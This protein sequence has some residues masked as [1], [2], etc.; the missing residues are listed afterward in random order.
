MP[1]ALYWH[2]SN[3]AVSVLENFQIYAAKKIQRFYERVPNLV[4]LYAVDEAGAFRASQENDVHPLCY[5][6]E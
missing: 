1:T 4:C 2:L 3:G 6:P 5:G